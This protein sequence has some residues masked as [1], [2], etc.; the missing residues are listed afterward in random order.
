MT[1][2]TEA[3]VAAPTAAEVI[4][5]RLAALKERTI[6]RYGLHPDADDIQNALDYIKELQQPAE[7]PVPVATKGAK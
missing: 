3:P 7:V 4:V 6:M 2:T 5:E 1:D